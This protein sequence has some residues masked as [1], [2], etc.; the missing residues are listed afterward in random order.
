M[1]AQQIPLTTLKYKIVIGYE[2]VLQNN[3]VPCLVHYLHQLQYILTEVVLYLSNVHYVKN[4]FAQQ[5]P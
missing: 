5:V 3:F 4:M 1:F 2:H